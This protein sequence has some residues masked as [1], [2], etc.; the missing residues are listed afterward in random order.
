MPN[1]HP[2]L[3]HFPIA[4][5]VTAVVCD[6]LGLVSKK[7]IFADSGTIATAGALIGAATAVLSGLIAEE[8]VWHTPAAGEILETHETMGF[9]FLGLIVFLALLRLAFRN[10]LSGRLAWLTLVI[11]VFGSIIVIFTAY[12]GGEMVYYHGAGVKAAEECEAKVSSLEGQIKKL[13]DSGKA[14]ENQ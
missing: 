12:L 3:V 8:T 5:I 7:R 6:L 10:K 13:K 4:L 9:V 1:I 11:G 2:M 14:S